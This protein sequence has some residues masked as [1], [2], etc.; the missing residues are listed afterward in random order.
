MTLEKA[1]IK[2]HLPRGGETIE[3][4]FNPTQY[5]LS[6]SNQFAEVGVPGLAAPLLQFG[7]GNASVLSMQL[8]FD[9]FEQ[10]EDVRTHTAK[11][12]ALLEL[13]HELHAPPVCLFTWGHLNFVGVI[14]RA[15][16]TFTLFLADG[17]PV[18][19]TLDVSFKEFY[20]G[21]PGQ[22]QSANYAKRYIVQRGDTLSSIAGHMYE[23]PGLWRHIA[24]AN[25]IDNPLA[26]RPGQMLKIPAIE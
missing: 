13:D 16:Q 20:Q 21:E 4:L 25:R 12:M 26:L 22:L 19:A 18:R 8:F 9:T 6:K 10:G 14:E 1:T 17:T 5:K 23:N 24:E 3:V 7:R 2:R 11:V 15:D